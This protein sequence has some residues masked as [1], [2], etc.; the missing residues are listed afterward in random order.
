MG[1]PTVASWFGPSRLAA[2]SATALRQTA[3]PGARRRERCAIETLYREHNDALVRFLRHRLR[4]EADVREVAQEAYCRL[5]QVKGSCEPV[6]LRAYL[7]RIAGNAATD[8]QRRRALMQRR[9]EAVDD[10][11]EASQERTLVARETLALVDRALAGLPVRCREAFVLSREREWST[12]EI[13]AHLGVSD[14]MVRL[15]LIRALDHILAATE[16]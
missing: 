3:Q 11:E 9:D 7:F 12:I 2:M 5:L 10:V 13:G 16:A 8:L 15:Y 1:A 14:R 6:F 4:N